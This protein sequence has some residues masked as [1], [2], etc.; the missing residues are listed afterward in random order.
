MPIYL[1][2]IDY[3]A[4]VIF[5]IYFAGVVLGARVFW[6]TPGKV[7]FWALVLLLESIAAIVLLT[8]MSSKYWGTGPDGII[9]IAIGPLISS[10][11]QVFLPLILGAI[12]VAVL[13]YVSIRLSKTR[14]STAAFVLPCLL[15]PVLF[16]LSTQQFLIITERNKPV[17]QEALQEIVIA[18]GFKIERFLTEPAHNPTG[19]IFG[20]DGN[21]YVSN[22]NGDI[23]GVSME[24]GSSWKYSTG[25]RVPVGMAWHEG[26][27][28]VASHG[29]ISVVRDKNGDH[30]G[31]S[32]EDII[33]GLPARL[34]P[35]HANNGVVFG[36]DNRIYFAVGAT[37]DRSEE[38]YEYAATI[39]SANPDGSDL[40]TFA[41]G[42]RNPYRLAFNSQGDLFATD[43]GPDGMEVT[44]GDELNHIVEG[45][46]YGFPHAFGLPPPGS[47][48]HG[49]V[50]LFPPHAS[51]DGLVFYQGDKFPQE[52]FD[53]A[54][55][56]LWHL[57]EIYR[58]ELTKNQNGTYSSRLSQ[59][60]I[61]LNAPLDLA[62]GPDGSM[63]V[64]DFNDSVIYKITYT[65]EN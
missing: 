35:W 45:R 27:L 9:G 13:A 32:V 38:T 36:P 16:A 23:W 53:N 56:A 31:D 1:S 14:Y 29:K 15:I 17:V 20:P 60:V 19:I 4:L 58:I 54:F 2:L 24:D 5:T 50:A 44:P 8:L 22:Y 41:T 6:K 26:E 39:L 28:Y 62:V 47:D 64:I 55:V 57:G 7:R 52:Y 65:G 30:T 49:P 3:V 12:V 18:P 51:A 63:Y 21:L 25:F 42:V 61:G 10:V 34:Y 40:R 11:T 37:S 33:T 43:N 46:D 59:F 48:V